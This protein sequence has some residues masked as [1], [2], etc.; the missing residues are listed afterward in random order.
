MKNEYC[1]V[2]VLLHGLY[3]M[4]FNSNNLIAKAP[5]IGMHCYASGASG[6]II[7]IPKEYKPYQIDLTTEIAGLV[8]GKKNDF[9]EFPQIP[10]FSKSGPNGVGD[11]TEAQQVALILPYPADII[12]LRCA[13]IDD[14]KAIAQD[15]EIKN[16]IVDACTNNNNDRL[17]LVTCLRYLKQRENG[18]PPAATYSFYAEHR[19]IPTIGQMNCTYCEAKALFN[20]GDNFDL[21]LHLPSTTKEPVA[22]PPDPHPG[23]GISADD[24]LSLAEFMGPV[25]STEAI[26]VA[27]CVQFAVTG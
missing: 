8:P 14:F 2:N 22:I 1:Y 15:G 9:S 10:Q 19:M 3:F 6:C 18:S 26:H 21:Q 25:N 24:E 12:P 17:S 16:R 13:H 5:A 7:E 23:Y 20:N 27:N 4:E 11:L